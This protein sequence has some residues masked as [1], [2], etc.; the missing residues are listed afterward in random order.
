VVHVTDLNRAKFEVE[1]L[2]RDRP[3]AKFA[4]ADDRIT[5]RTYLP[6]APFVPSH[7]RETLAM[8]CV[9]A[10]EIDDDLAVRV[11]G[12]RFVEPHASQDADAESDG[13]NKGAEELHPAMLTLLQLDADRPGSIKPSMAAKV[14]GYDP[15]LL[16]QLIRWNEEQEIEWRSARDEARMGDLGEE[17]KV[18]DHERKHAHRTTKLL[19]KALRYVVEQEETTSI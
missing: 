13:D 15:G 5:A 10:D 18:C 8:M 3:F 9:L 19:R 14:C 11:S 6:A 4:L 16:L 1:I 17:A 7:L 12:R 2:N